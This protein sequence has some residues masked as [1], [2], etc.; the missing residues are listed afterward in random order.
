[1]NTPRGF[2]PVGESAPGLP[3]HDAPLPGHVPG[4]YQPLGGSDEGASFNVGY[5]DPNFPPWFGVWSGRIAYFVANY[6][7]VP[8]QAAL[9]PI[10]GA[11]GLVAGTVTYLLMRL[12]GA[13]IDRAHD[14]A[15][16]ACF[17]GLMALMRTEI[18]TESSNPSYTTLRQWLRLG[19]CFV[20]MFYLAVREQHDSAGTAFIVSAIFTAIMFFVLRS[21]WVRFIWHG[22]QVMAWMRPAP[23]G[24]ATPGSPATG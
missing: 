15:W 8:I 20:A 19:T 22:L 18:R 3:R 11:A 17:L 1:M 23:E 21:R 6:I 2:N 4:Q 24:V 13:G 5:K 16:T 12:V 7:T 14:W 10:A 9:Y